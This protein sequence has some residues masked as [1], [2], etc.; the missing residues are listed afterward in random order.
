MIQSQTI[1]FTSNSFKS[2]DGTYANQ[3]YINSL[4]NNTAEGAEVIF[5]GTS[6]TLLDALS[7]KEE[8][9]EGE[10][11]A[12]Q[13][14]DKNLLFGEATNPDNGKDASNVVLDNGQVQIRYKLLQHPTLEAMHC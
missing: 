7:N 4:V 12:V 6:E 2:E 9:F 10:S 8:G 13:C 14:S 11:A 5:N 1:N 3:S